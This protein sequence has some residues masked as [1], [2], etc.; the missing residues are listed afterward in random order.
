M[1]KGWVQEVQE[2]SIVIRGFNSQLMQQLD[3]AQNMRRKL[4][5]DVR[6]T[7]TRY[8]FFVQHRALN[9]VSQVN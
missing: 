9:L 1:Q 8:P 2:K 4:L 5:L 6:F 7:F 3:T